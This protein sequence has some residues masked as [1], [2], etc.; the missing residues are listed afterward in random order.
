MKK[1]FTHIICCLAV[2]VA[3]AVSV[4]A[5][6]VLLVEDFEDGSL[7]TGWS[8][9]QQ[10]GSNGWQFGITTYTSG[11]WAIPAHPSGGNLVT[12]A[13][14]DLCDCD[15]SSDELWTPTMDWSPFDSV[16]IIFDSFFDAAWGGEAT[17]EV[18][19]D[20]GS[21]W[22][23]FFIP[24]SANWW[25]D[26]GAVLDA[27]TFGPFTNN[28]VVR[29]KYNDNGGWS[30]GFAIDNVLILG[31]RDVCDDVVTIPG[32]G[33]PQ[34]VNLVG[35]G[36]FYWD[37]DECW[38]TP[39][40]EQ[41][42]QF[43]APTTG[44]YNIEVTSSNGEWIDYLWKPVLAGCDTNGWTCISDVVG[45]G[46]YGTIP[47]IAGQSI[48]ILADAE[49]FV[50]S[51]QTFQVLCPCGP[52]VMPPGTL[53]GELCGDSIND[54][55]SGSNP[56]ALGSL[57]CGETVV[58]NIFANAGS[59]DL[60]WYEFTVNSATNVTLSAS[61]DFAMN[62]VILGF[63]GD[64]VG[65]GFEQ[66]GACQTATISTSLNAGTYLALVGP[67][68]FEGHPC[69]GINNNYW[70]SLSLGTPTA[71]ISPSSPISVCAGETTTLTAGGSGGVAPYSYVWHTNA[72]TQALPGV[73]GGTTA[74][75]TVTDANLCSDSTSA[76][77]VSVSAPVADFSF[78]QSAMMVN[79]ADL[80]AP[81]PNTW[82]WDFGDGN[83]SIAQSPSNTYNGT[84]GTYIVGMVAGVNPGCLDTAAYLVNVSATGCAPQF[85]VGPDVDDHLDGF[86]LGNYSTTNGFTQFV[87]YTDNTGSAIETLNRGGTYNLTFHGSGSDFETFAAWIDYNN[88]GAFEANELLGECN[89]S[90]GSCTIS[91]TVPANASTGN[92][93]IRLTSQED[94]TS[95]VDPCGTSF[96]YGETEDYTVFIDFAVGTGE[97]AQLN[98]L[99]VYPN[100][101]EGM[102]NVSF[103]TEDANGLEVRITNAVGQVVFTDARNYFNGTYRNTI[104]VSNLAAGNYMLQV[105]TEKGML[106][107]KV[108]V[109]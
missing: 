50:S 92:T 95:N 12:A 97:L 22:E 61:G 46:I 84:P 62:L 81:T 102:L 79:F 87:A 89:S 9:M 26:I 47:L 44:T 75:V 66:A 43:T 65:F 16:Y 4:Q 109:R 7:P 103:E 20:G 29:F 30:D 107:T 36:D 78:S 80:S 71:S 96:V 91:F 2:I 100:P 23:T 31:F 5:Q 73:A 60:D 54:G 21:N 55:C 93:A 39:G 49:G 3:T 27:A 28:T 40:W 33:S 59:R 58:G 8:R 77:V 17:V 53:E 37:F 74:M 72:T 67:V 51:Q 48:Y 76:S 45:E 56:L 94:V 10:T 90:S 85:L 98:N 69:G 1:I 13:N 42:Y 34:N 108:V 70:V 106:N 88:N 68:G 82:F 83:T 25:L 38:S 104:D 18:S 6:S 19:N 32:C 105:L 15:A 64:T 86:D 101:T 24:D 57:S 14:D 63:C 41:L 52:S 11:Y 99:E 35:L